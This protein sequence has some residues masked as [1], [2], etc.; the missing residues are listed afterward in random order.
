MAT[1]PE[2]IELE[3]VT[4]ERY[5]LNERVAA[6][7]LPGKD[8]YLGVLPGHA[9][10]LTEMGIGV[11]AYRKDGSTGYLSIVHGYAEV[12]PGRVIVLAEISERAEEI[13]VERSRTARD[14]AQAALSQAPAGAGEWHLASF[15]LA[16]ALARLQ[17]AS[18]AGRHSGAPTSEK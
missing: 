14:R 2:S 3:V 17:A 13:D 18:R 4:P 7:E 11:L 12:L 9:P 15:D 8:G 1:L 16:R 6:I 10:L 5:V